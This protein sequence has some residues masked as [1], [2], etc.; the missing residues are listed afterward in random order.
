MTWTDALTD[1][2]LPMGR[3]GRRIDARRIVVY[4]HEK[5]E[6]VPEIQGCELPHQGAELVFR[7]E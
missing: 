7:K 1:R 6:A 2:A 4:H 5:D 3:G